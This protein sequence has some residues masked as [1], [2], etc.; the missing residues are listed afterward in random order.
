MMMKTNKR[1]NRAGMT[2]LEVVMAVSIFTIVMGTL[3]GLALSMGDTARLQEAEVN[4]S[5]SG[6]NVLLSL[7]SELRQT[8]MQNLSA[9]N[10]LP[11]MLL[12]YRVADDIDGNGT[13]SSGTGTLELGPAR[14]VRVDTE[15]LNKDGLTSTQLVV[16]QGGVVV[17]VLSNNLD[18]RAETTVDVDGNG[19]MDRGFWVASAGTGLNI[20][21]QTQQ[22][23][24][25]GRLVTASHT[26]FVKPRN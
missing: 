17:Q 14:T 11:A 20:T 15:D 21:V 6:R 18:P 24:R 4:I 13:A 22:R 19:V 23:L 12:N 26:A 25:N 3:F 9:S 8:Q 16:V 1:K 10:N 7:V 5:E 2:L